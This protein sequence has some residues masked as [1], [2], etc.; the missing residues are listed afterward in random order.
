M[1]YNEYYISFGGFNLIVAEDEDVG[2]AVDEYVIANDI[3]EDIIDWYQNEKL[4]KEEVKNCGMA[5]CS[6]KVQQDV[7]GKVL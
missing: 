3:E 6:S 5:N 1:K 7:W 2:D 4:T